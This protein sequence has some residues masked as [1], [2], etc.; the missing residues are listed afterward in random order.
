MATI[1][2]DLEDMN[3]VSPKEKKRRSKD[4]KRESK[5]RERADKRKTKEFK[6]MSRELAKEEHRR[7]RDSHRTK[8]GKLRLPRRI[9]GF[10]SSKHNSE[11]Q[12]VEIGMPFNFQKL[13]H[14]EVDSDSE[15]GLKGL[16][17]EW[18]VLL[19]ASGISK[20]D[21]TTNPEDVLD[22][23][24]F[25]M[26]GPKPQLPSK[27][28]LKELMMEKWEIQAGDPNKIF[29]KMKKLG[30]G[31]GGVV[32]KV[33]DLRS[34]EIKAVK[35]AP[36]DELMYIKQEIAMHAMSEHANIVQYGEAIM[37][38]EEIWIS[39]E[40]IDGGC[41]Y[42]LIAGDKLPAWSEPNMAYVC[43]QVLIGLTF[44]HRKHLLHRDI[45]SDNVLVGRNGVVKLADFGF[46]AGLTREQD[47]RSSAV[48]T[49]YWMAPEVIQQAEYDAKVDVWSLG[50][51]AMEM[52]EGDPPFME[53]SPM[54][55]MLL[56]VQ[57]T[58]GPKLK[59][60]SKWSNIYIE[61]LAR[62]LHKNPESR[63]P[64]ERLLLDDEFIQQAGSKDAFAQWA[65]SIFDKK[66]KKK[67]FT[68]P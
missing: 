47:K 46:A 59:K 52:A 36:K 66:Q 7:S 25:H 60:P 22:V 29:R 24:R 55:A 65:C 68:Q 4:E 23:L 17:Q 13:S 28:I 19:K 40:L 35:V 61:F 14:V 2:R 50:I 8:S 11:P 26:D 34:G 42:D 31:A 45:K 15:L 41:L 56:I 27:D 18:E 12:N 48:G 51:T 64:S 62:C 37:Y 33:T 54:R 16:P 32:Y 44:M 49:P 63:W 20:E 58:V 6:R 30:E 21:V 9:T 5:D 57:Q 10:F 43:Q 1:V 3:I 53:E 39:M 67:N 38:K